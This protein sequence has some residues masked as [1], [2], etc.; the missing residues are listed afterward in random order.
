MFNVLP[1][2]DTRWK[3]MQ[4]GYRLVF[5]PMPALQ[6]LRQTPSSEA[7]WKDLWE[8]LHHQ[9]DVGEASYAA[10]IALIALR[11]EGVGFDWNFPALISLIEA[12]RGKDGNPGLPLWLEA[13]Y[14]A[15]WSELLP[16][17]FEDIA[18]LDSPEPFVLRALLS[19][20]AIAKKADRL[21]TFLFTVDE[22]EIDNYFDGVWPG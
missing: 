5:D 3:Q 7:A 20:V 16:M 22:S 14:F 19:A 18:A 15:A 12:R 6:V 8:N 17:L 21:G 9:N 4:G 11:R 10:A 1:E 13:D 2:N